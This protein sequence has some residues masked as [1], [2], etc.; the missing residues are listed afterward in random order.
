M[1]I[2]KRNVLI[3]SE[4]VSEQNPLIMRIPKDEFM[5][6]EAN[7]SQAAISML[8]DNIIDCILVD[9]SFKENQIADVVKT[10]RELKEF[11]M[12]PLIVVCNTAIKTNMLL[13]L[14]ESGAD[15]CIDSSEE[16]SIFLSRVKGH[17]RVRQFYKE[18]KAANTKLF[19]KN[20]DLLRQDNIKDSFISNITHE[21]RTPL[22][23]IK[24]GLNI[25]IK[26]QAGSINNEQK[27]FL[28]SSNRNIDR[29]LA[30]INDLLVI[31]KVDSGKLE[32]SYED[33]NPIDF[34]DEIIRS[35]TL[36]AKERNIILKTDTK[37]SSGLIN[38]DAN[39]MFQVFANLISNTFKY[40]PEGGIVEVGAKTEGW[41]INLWVKDNGD[42]IPKE[43]LGSVF[44]DFYQTDKDLLGTLQGTGLGMMIA[45][46]LV[47][48]HGGKI[49]IQS[50]EKKGT[51]INVKIPKQK[52]DEIL[53]YEMFTRE[54]DSA[55]KSGWKFCTISLKCN[56]WDYLVNKYSNEVISDYVNSVYRVVRHIATRP[57]DTIFCLP[58]GEFMIFLSQTNITGG[59]F[60]LKRI[61][62][63]LYNTF[64]SPGDEAVSFELSITE[65]PMSD[66]YKKMDM[67]FISVL[68]IIDNEDL[69]NFISC[70]FREEDVEINF[71]KN[72]KDAKQLIL[73]QQYDLVIIDN[74][75]QSTDFLEIFSKLKKYIRKTTSCAALVDRNSKGD[76]ITGIEKHRCRLLRKPVS[77]SDLAVLLMDVYEEKMNG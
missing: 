27:K 72:E 5:P 30:V 19:Y 69:A 49:W 10:I 28:D 9:D 31:S 67:S 37:G 54:F 36:I 50:S 76:I 71:A 44:D 46:K 16:N 60:V 68:L 62:K 23:I 53:F 13:Q 33:I 66:L 55:V 40:T 75:M 15:D 73:A 57:S 52:R 38:V 4:R 70:V 22:A 64:C 77:L 12:I 65:Y 7:A 3:I 61:Q 18:L 74:D 29:A 39:K 6:F 32:L 21:L 11:Q 26:E 34:I 1:P 20:Q 43:A 59:E 45:K 24:E 25:V 35:F 51:I 2:N 14:F 63:E 56:D 42:G 47:E 41:Y 48:A 17:I 8:K 58:E